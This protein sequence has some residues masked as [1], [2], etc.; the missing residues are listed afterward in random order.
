[1]IHH[2]TF[3][4]E[5]LTLSAGK[6]ADSAKS[7]GCHTS[8]IYEPE[9]IDK[10]FA[11]ENKAILSQARGAGYWLWKPYFIEKTMRWS[12]QNSFVV[13][14]DAGILFE[15][16][17]LHLVTAMDGDIM[18]F[19][20]RWIHGEWC[21]MDV[22]HAM[23]CNKPEFIMHEQVQASC[24]IVR[25]TDYAHQ[26]VEFWL[27]ACQEPGFIDDSPSIRPNVPGFREHRHDQAILTNVAL[28]Y[29]IP[30]HWWPAQYSLRHR[31]RYPNDK[32]PVMFQHHRKR[33]NEW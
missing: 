1:M 12:R 2:I 21:K 26:L 4:D 20:N 33:N 6:C 3:T 25:N 14:T 29:D 9:D 28:F 7:H 5:N 19:G 8:I 32:Y 16:D 27:K 22:L 18:V 24:I 11:L 10:T 13:Y 23:D 17:V 15:N 30:F 31:N